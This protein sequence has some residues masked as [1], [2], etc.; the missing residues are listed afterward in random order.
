MT[1]TLDRSQDPR[2]RCLRTRTT[3][4]QDVKWQGARNPNWNQE[5]HFSQSNYP[6]VH[7]RQNDSKLA[8]HQMLLLI[9][10]LLGHGRLHELKL[11]LRAFSNP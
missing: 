7:V 3:S 2:N 10:F 11:E 4:E 5:S 6:Y 1:Q 8:K 9:F